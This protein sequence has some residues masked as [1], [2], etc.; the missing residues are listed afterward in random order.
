MTCKFILITFRL[1]VTVELKVRLRLR[2]WQCWCCRGFVSIL[3]RRWAPP[4]EVGTQR[5][6]TAEAQLG[7]EQSEDDGD[8]HV[9]GE[10][11]RMLQTKLLSLLASDNLSN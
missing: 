9:G 10:Q 8:L 4:D 5:R 11:R 6:L 2:N 3:G 1:L 7:K